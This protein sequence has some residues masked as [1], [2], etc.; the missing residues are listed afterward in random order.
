MQFT[1][2]ELRPLAKLLAERL[3][4]DGSGYPRPIVTFSRGGLDT[5]A[6]VARFLPWKPYVL[7]FDPGQL[8]N[9]MELRR[10]PNPVFIDDLLDTGST[11]GMVHRVF[12][13]ISALPYLVLFDKQHANRIA[14]PPNLFAARTVQTEDWIVFPWEVES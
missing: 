9:G 1:Y 14:T 3:V 10:L 13:G 11:Y 4:A 8:V 12:P 6:L 2:Q 7:A 5:T